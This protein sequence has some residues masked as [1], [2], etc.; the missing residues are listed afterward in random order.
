MILRV[1]QFS[2]VYTNYSFKAPFHLTFVLL[3]FWCNWLWWRSKHPQENT[4]L[5]GIY[6]GQKGA[7]GGDIDKTTVCTFNINESIEHSVSDDFQ[8]LFFIGDCLN[9]VSHHPLDV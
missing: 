4:I 3:Y 8:I 6:G 2:G 5:S 1:A 7:C 9:K